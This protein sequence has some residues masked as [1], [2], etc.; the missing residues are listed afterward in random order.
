MPKGFA[1]DAETSPVQSSRV[2]GLGVAAV[3]DSEVAS[4]LGFLNRL[5]IRFM[6]TTSAR[7]RS[8][9]HRANEGHGIDRHHQEVEEL[10]YC[11]TG[12]A[13]HDRWTDDLPSDFIHFED[14]NN[15]TSIAR[16]D[17]MENG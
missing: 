2:L 4:S 8:F 1:P 12:Q 14:S 17:E 10:G 7:T 6:F 15:P 11:E 9:Y 3:L 13:V 5:R 16:S